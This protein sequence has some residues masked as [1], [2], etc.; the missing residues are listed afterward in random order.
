[1][2][3]NGSASFKKG[4]LIYLEGHLQTRKWVDKDSIER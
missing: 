4:A 2:R 3:L 1:M